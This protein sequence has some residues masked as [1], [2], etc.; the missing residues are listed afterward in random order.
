M[1]SL[2][3]SGPAVRFLSVKVS[4]KAPKGT[5]CAELLCSVCLSLVGC[6]CMRLGLSF[7][8]EPEGREFESLRARHSSY[9]LSLSQV[10]SV[11]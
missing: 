11:S 4:R 7:P 2:A 5:N 6:C 9:P 10:P 1:I 8:Y 3:A